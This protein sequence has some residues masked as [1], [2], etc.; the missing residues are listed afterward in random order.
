VAKIQAE[1]QTRIGNSSV[2]YSVQ[3]GHGFH[4][5]YSSVDTE[6]IFSWNK[7]DVT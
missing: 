7:A 4:Q 1:I 2:G 3:I 6:V 5:F